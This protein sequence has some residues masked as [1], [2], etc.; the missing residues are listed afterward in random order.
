METPKSVFLYIVKPGGIIEPVPSEE[1]D[2]RTLTPE[3]WD[4]TRWARWMHEF[5]DTPFKE[6]GRL[7]AK[8]Y[9]HQGG[10]GS[11]LVSTMFLGYD[12]GGPTG[13]PVLFE[14]RIFGVITDVKMKV[15]LGSHYTSYEDAL[16]GHART[17]AAL[18]GNQIGGDNGG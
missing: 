18:T 10:P 4:G 16:A 15:V 17:I 13:D 1:T 5:K 9:I 2:I 12:I 8:D 14:T 6:G 11:T 7:V 3:D